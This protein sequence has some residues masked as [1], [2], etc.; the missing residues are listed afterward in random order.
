[1]KFISPP[2]GIGRVTQGGGGGHLT[3]P[4]VEIIL[5]LC[6]LSRSLTFDT[7]SRSFS[8]YY[9]RFTNTATQWLTFEN[10][11]MLII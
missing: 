4:S 9:F 1:M 3:T 5:I 10:F 7:F 6:D 2:P 8:R 11:S